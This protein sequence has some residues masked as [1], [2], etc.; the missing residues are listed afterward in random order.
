MYK[1]NL[2]PLICIISII[3]IIFF[4]NIFSNKSKEKFKKVHFNDENDSNFQGKTLKY[5]G[6]HG[7]PHS[8]Q[9]SQMYNLIQQF[10]EFIKKNNLNCKVKY[11]WAGENNNDQFLLAKADYVPTLTNNN[12]SHVNFKL[13]P[14]EFEK[15]KHDEKAL[16]NA[17]F[18]SMY[19]KL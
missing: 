5:F 4:L 13:Q 6:S 17:V 19:N 3:S 12:N 9:N 8:N 15:Y 14:E 11:F 7:C 16:N 1:K 18:L 10:E 2:V